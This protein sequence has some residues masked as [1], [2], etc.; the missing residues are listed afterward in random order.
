MEA[1]PDGN[2]CD[3][4]GNGDALPD[5]L[6]FLPVAADLAL[7]ALNEPSA[8]ELSGKTKLNAALSKLEKESK[9][10]NANWK[11]EERFHFQI[12]DLSPVLVLNL[13]VGTLERFSVFAIPAGEPE[14]PNHEWKKV[15]AE[16]TRDNEAAPWEGVT[17]YPLHSGP[18]GHIRFL[19]KLESG[20]CAGSPDLTYDAREW[21]PKGISGE[22]DLKQIIDQKGSI[23]WDGEAKGKKPTPKD[24]F[25]AN[26]KLE[27]KGE[28]ITLPYCWFSIIDASDHPSLCTLDTYDLTGD[29]VGFVSRA[30][31][32]PDIAPI[33]NAVEHAKQHELPAVQAYCANTDIARKLVHD[34]PPYIFPDNLQIKQT[35]EDKERVEFGSPTIYRFEMEK[36]NGQ[37]L[38]AAFSEQ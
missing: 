29:L 5:M 4:P 20:G 28:L 13:R 2:S 18:S 6:S 37:W 30:Y 24:P 25:A 22:G 12:L 27:T 17:L 19:A 31:N 7:E 26:G 33:V 14:K 3:G 21:D 1:F 23:N 32:R 15:G 10:I 16:N 11:K 34:I 9:E 35:A 38:I 8:P 36:Q